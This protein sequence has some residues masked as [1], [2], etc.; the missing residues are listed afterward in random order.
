M[1]REGYIKIVAESYFGN[2]S[3]GDIDAVLAC[4]TLD[5]TVTIRHGDNPSRTFSAD[6]SGGWPRLRL[7][8]EHL[9]GNYEPWFGEFVHY[10]DAENQRAACTF[11]VRLTPGS[12]SDY[13]AAGVQE[14]KNC[15]FFS[16]TGDKIAEMTIYYSNSADSAK[17]GARTPTGYPPRGW[18]K[19]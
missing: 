1:D 11:T 6:G 3:A 5:A 15:N 12:G 14:L 17:G 4:F 16:F 19:T 10:V 7:F 9:C 2:V 13:A 8:Y 18:R